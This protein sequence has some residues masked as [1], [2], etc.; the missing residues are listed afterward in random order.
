MKLDTYCEAGKQKTAEMSVT[1][2]CHNM[3][4]WIK[5]F[6]VDLEN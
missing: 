2:Q 5:L 1:Q 6:F 4:I 3:W